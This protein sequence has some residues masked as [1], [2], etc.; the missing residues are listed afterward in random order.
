MIVVAELAGDHDV[1]GCH[2]LHHELQCHVVDEE[3][4]GEGRGGWDSAEQCRCQ[5]DENGHGCRS[6]CTK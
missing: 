4:D 5:G 1:V 2:L 3:I 6:A